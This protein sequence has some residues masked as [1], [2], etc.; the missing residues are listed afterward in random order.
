MTACS[1]GAKAKRVVGAA[2]DSKGAKDD[3]RSEQ[4]QIR[5]KRPNFGV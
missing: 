3:K 2:L 4:N 5:K 1:K